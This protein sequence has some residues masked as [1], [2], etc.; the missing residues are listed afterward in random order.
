MAET[1]D[2]NQAWPG[3]VLILILLIIRFCAGGPRFFSRVGSTVLSWSKIPYPPTPV[4]GHNPVKKRTHLPIWMPPFPD[5]RSR[6]CGVR[7]GQHFR[8]TYPPTPKKNR[9]SYARRTHLP[10]ENVPPLNTVLPTPL[11]KRGPGTY[12]EGKSRCNSR[13][14]PIHSFFLIFLCCSYLFL[15]LH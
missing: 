12:V 11:K 6:W 1:A 13:P 14:V 8:P 7:S 5:S 3:I 9:S 10:K 15:F 2:R 4:K